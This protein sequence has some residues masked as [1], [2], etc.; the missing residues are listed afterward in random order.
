[1]AKIDYSYL[2]YNVGAKPD[3]FA[4]S[5]GQSQNVLFS[6]GTNDVYFSFP[7]PINFTYTENSVQR[8]FVINA[9][10]PPQSASNSIYVYSLAANRSIY[11]YQ[12]IFMNTKIINSIGQAGVIVPFNYSL[13]Y[14]GNSIYSAHTNFVLSSLGLNQFNV[15]FNIDNKTPPGT[16]TLTVSTSYNTNISRLSQNVTLLPYHFAVL[17]NSSS[18]G[19]FGGTSSLTIKNDGNSPLSLNGTVL[20][21]SSF[22]SIFISSESAS[23]G[24]V[25]STSSGF[26]SSLIDLAP[27]QE[28]TISYSVSYYPVYLAIIVIAAAILLVMYFNRKVVVSKEVIE[29]RAS[30]GFIDVKLA[31]R[32][33]NISKKPLTELTITDSAPQTA[34]KVSMIGPKEGKVERTSHGMRFVWKELELS[35]GDELIL[36][37]EIK[38]KIGIVGSVNLSPAECTF[39]YGNKR[40]SKKSNSL[41]L[42]IR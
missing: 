12:S 16:Y 27:G 7:I 39:K 14:D 2:F 41:I 33:K 31:I 8:S 6:F 42:N 17:S 32:V 34:L 13:L 4:L 3:T 1:M 15:S 38:S 28:L 19:Y 35:A 11:P 22:N 36:M 10:I 37:Y 5:P 20:P 18:F 24:S 21:L 9:P 29:R 25:V 40:H 23:I 30:G 26:M